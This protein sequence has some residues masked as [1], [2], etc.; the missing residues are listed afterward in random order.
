MKKKVA[1]IIAL[2]ILVLLIALG[3]S[4]I[5]SSKAVGI[6]DDM[7][8]SGSVLVK[9]N[10]TDKNVVIPGDITGIGSEAFAGNTF[11]ETVTVSSGVSEIGS[12]AFSGCTGLVTV[13]LPDTVETIGDSAFSDCPKLSQINFGKDFRKLGNGVFSGDTSLAYVNIPPSNTSFV[14][15]DGCIYN[16][17][18]T[19]LYQYLPGY[20]GN[21]Y[22][23]PDSVDTVCQYAFWGTDK[24][25]QITCSSSL[26]EIPSYSFAGATALSNVYVNVPA[27]SIGIG[28]FMGDSSLMQ[29]SLPISV[30]D[31]KESAFSGCP[32]DMIIIA[33]EG[34]F[35][36]RYAE[37]KGYLTAAEPKLSVTDNNLKYTP[38][39]VTSVSDIPTV[40]SGGIITNTVTGTTSGNTAIVSTGRTPMYQ[41]VIEYDENASVDGNVIG[42]SMVVSDRAFVIIESL[43]AVSGT[44]EAEPEIVTYS[45][46]E[47][48]HYNDQTI[49]TY[50]FDTGDTSIG[51]LSFAR[52]SIQSIDIPEG[53]TEI[54]YGA[55]YHCDSLTDVSIP[56][57][58]T[59]VGQY[60]F[61]H[62]PWYENWLSD[63]NAPDFLIV[64]DGVLIGYKGTDAEPEIPDSVKTVAEGVF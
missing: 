25:N 52:S 54:A 8:L 23:M 53:V 61:D 26:S 58:V 48:S 27:K 28:A 9:Y 5:I 55:F 14:W 41:H 39:S 46:P 18:K 10:G 33:D 11:V 50:T 38:V 37:E 24:L 43:P 17:K 45:V 2:P 49:D 63:E 36:Y 57:T 35:A 13:S 47:Y 19:V 6:T 51:M 44:N 3:V 29:V 31:I 22:R 62:T 32:T 1:L 59:A 30:T 16:Y 7:V 60:A 34:T 4:G 15:D 40:S 64:G 20:P 21:V 42:D 12:K 56:S